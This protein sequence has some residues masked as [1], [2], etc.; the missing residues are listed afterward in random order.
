MGGKVCVR[1]QSTEETL[2]EDGYIQAS[3]VGDLRS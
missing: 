1:L 2:F 3:K